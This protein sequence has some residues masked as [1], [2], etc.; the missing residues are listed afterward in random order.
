[1]KHGAKGD[2]KA[3]DTAAIQATI[4][5]CH[6]Q[7]G[8][9]VLFLPGTFLSGSL[10]LKSGVAFHLDHAATLLASKD[11]KPGYSPHK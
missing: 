4:D 8:G 1:V 10:H 9:T 2:G 7:G 11:Q 5:A 6:R 3:K